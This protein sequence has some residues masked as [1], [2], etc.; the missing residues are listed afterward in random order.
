MFGFGRSLC[1]LL[2]VST[3]TSL[4]AA[5]Q[6]HARRPQPAGQYSTKRIVMADANLASQ[7]LSTLAHAALPPALASDDELL[8]VA[9]RV[10]D[11][12]A[13]ER[14]G[15]GNAAKEG[16]IGIRPTLVGGVNL[17]VFYAIYQ[18]AFQIYL[19]VKN[20]G[21]ANVSLIDGKR[22]VDGKRNDK[23]AFGRQLS[24]EV[25]IEASR[26]GISGML[27]GGKSKGEIQNNPVTEVGS[28]AATVIVLGALVFG[29]LNPDY[30]EDIAQKSQ[31]PCVEKI[32][33][34]KKISCLSSAS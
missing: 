9:Q 23:D 10:S 8:Q 18:V 13:L 11:T 34:G 12:E 17:F 26:R 33:R 24:Q 25:E 31:G 7:F 27:G 28:L 22:V 14:F 1:S 20:P 5:Y 4:S 30:V 32:V 15:L 6:I 16:D 19:R 21:G 29:A 3:T 2:L